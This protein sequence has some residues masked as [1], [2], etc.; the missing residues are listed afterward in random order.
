MAGKSTIEW[1][2]VTW[3]PVTGCTKISAGCKNCYAERMARRLRLMGSKRY[4]NELAVT[5]R[6]D[7]LDFP[8][9]LRAPRQIFVNSMS[10]LFHEAVPLEFIQ[11]AFASMNTSPQHAFQILTKRSERLA[12]LADKSHWSEN[13]W[14][15][16]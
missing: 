3:N 16:R 14:R 11:K 1:T 4:V 10:D 6:E 5:L 8:K 15:N 2:Q 7:L 9:T 12:E 13:I